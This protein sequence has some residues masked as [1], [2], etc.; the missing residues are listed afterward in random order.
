MRAFREDEE[1]K[2]FSASSQY[3]SYFTMNTVVTGTGAPNS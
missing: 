2:N 1:A 3:G